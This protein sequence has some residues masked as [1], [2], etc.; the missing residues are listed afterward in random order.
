MA[1]RLKKLIQIYYTW[2]HRYLPRLRHP[3]TLPLA[4]FKA[5]FFARPEHQWLKEDR[6]VF[7]MINYLWDILPLALRSQLPPELVFTYASGRL[8]CTVAA[9]GR[10]QIVIIFPELLKILHT[11]SPERG[12]AILGHELAHLILK[13]HQKKITPWAAQLEADQL[14]VVMGLGAELQEVIADFAPPW[15]AQIR[16]SKIA[17]ALPKTNPRP[18][19]SE[20]DTV[21]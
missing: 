8:A 16:L 6:T 3:R 1:P 9:S 15:E 19:I 14:V 5:Q 17:A 20:I 10:H 4:K 13:H 11:A 18:T 21:I 7:R 12:L 2:Y